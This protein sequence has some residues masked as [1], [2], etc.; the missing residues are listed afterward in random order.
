MDPARHPAADR[1]ERGRNRHTQLR[2][3]G[4]LLRRGH[5][6]AGHLRRPDHAAA[7][8]VQPGAEEPTERGG[9]GAG[10]PELRPAAIDLRREWRGASSRGRHHCEPAARAAGLVQQRRAAQRGV[11]ELR[12]RRRQQRFRRD[13][14][15]RQRRT[16][17]AALLAQP[18][19]HSEPDRGGISGRAERIPAGQSLGGGSGRRRAERAGDLGDAERHRDAGLRPGGAPSATESGQ[20]PARQYVHRVRHQREVGRD[21]ARGHYHDHLS[22][23]RVH[24]PAIPGSQDRARHEPSSLH[25]HGA[26]PRRRLVRGQQ[27][28]TGV[29]SGRRGPER[30]GS[31]HTAAAGG[32]R[33]GRERGE[34]VWNHG[35]FQPAIGRL[36]GDERLG[37]LGPAG[38]KRTGGARRS[39]GEPDRQRDGRG[40]AS[41]RPDAVLRLHGER[42]G[43]E[44]KPAVVRG[45]G[46]D[47]ERREPGDALRFEFCAG[48]RWPS[49]C[50][51]E[52]GRTTCSES[53]PASR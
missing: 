17:G 13:T 36:G 26:N 38:G 32:Q 7:L 25:H 34:P 5:Q 52:Q 24:S 18:G 21:P 37:E 46:R 19:G 14:E 39:A 45:D 23:G 2:G 15:A 3:G 28:A 35:E 20:I 50:T 12:I 43:R 47:C 41:R 27:R 44:R 30:R 53:R 16:L 4:G 1:V 10:S 51:G 22:Q 29:G 42:R 49:T 40:I 6:R 9:P 48:K 8:P 11:A 33:D 31:G